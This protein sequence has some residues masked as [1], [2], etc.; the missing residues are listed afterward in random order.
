MRLGC[1]T[2]AETKLCIFHIRESPTTIPELG[3]TRPVHPSTLPSLLIFFSGCHQLE[4][5]PSQSTVARDFP[6]Q[7]PAERSTADF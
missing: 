1:A 5:R 6:P 3:T 4:V 7:S 2:R